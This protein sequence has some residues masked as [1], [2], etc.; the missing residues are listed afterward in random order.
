MIRHILLK[1][2]VNCDT[3]PCDLAPAGCVYDDRVG[4]WRITSS[5]DLYIRSDMKNPPKTKK[6]D[7]ETGEDQKGE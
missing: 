3:R 6:Q 4:A 7:I 2:A 5:G 1:N